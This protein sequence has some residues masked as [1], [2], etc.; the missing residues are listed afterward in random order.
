MY[1]SAADLIV[2]KEPGHK[3]AIQAEF[4][5]VRDRMV[6]LNSLVNVPA[7]SSLTPHGIILA[8]LKERRVWCTYV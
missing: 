3:D 4:P 2:V 1:N 8:S 7:M 6:F 5:A